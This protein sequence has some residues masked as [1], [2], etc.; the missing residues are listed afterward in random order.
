[1]DIKGYVM[2]KT[3]ATIFLI[4]IAGFAN[5]TTFSVG[6]KELEIPLPKGFS[7]VTQEMDAVYRLS[8]Q[9]ADPV[10]DQLAFYIAESDV[11]FAMSGKIPSLE[12]YYILKVNKKLKD[13]VAGSKDFAELK[14]IT[15]RQNRKIFKSVETQMSDLIK[16]TN[17]GISKEFD[18]DFALKLSKVVPLNPHYETDNAFAYSMYINYGVTVKGSKE[19]FILSATTTFV[20]VAGKIL[21]LYCYGPQKDLEWTRSASKAW[22]GMVMGSNAQPPSNLSG[23]RGIDWSKVLEKGIVGA[24]AGGLIALLVG[25]FLRFKKKKG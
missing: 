21:F 16:K 6:G 8:L 18:I 19:D 17:K 10:N 14:S 23:G 2:K 25:V 7:L 4:F 15:K 20:N 24:I 22:A 11:P 9:M 13:M 12:R 3:L 5:A 1:M